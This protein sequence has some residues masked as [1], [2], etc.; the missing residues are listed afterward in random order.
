MLEL[1]LSVAQL[2]PVKL[3]NAVL[4][5]VHYLDDT[6]FMGSPRMKERVS[7]LAI[8]LKVLRELGISV[9]KHKTG[10]SQLPMSPA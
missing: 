1:R 6:L 8:A 5:H 3:N 10:E 9:A 7:V 4:S 2:L